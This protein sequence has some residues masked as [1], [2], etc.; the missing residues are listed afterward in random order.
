MDKKPLLILTAVVLA[1]GCVGFDLPQPLQ[2]KP[3][4]YLKG[5]DQLGRDTL[6]NRVLVANHLFPLKDRDSNEVLTILGQPQQVNIV[7]RNVSEDWYFVYYKKHV[8]YV[9]DA[10]EK[11]SHPESG[12]FL[13]RIYHDRVIDVVNID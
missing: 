7:E 8:A 12:T 4:T 11:I 5:G 3:Y 10:I 13:V 6:E 1:G 2:N 9:T